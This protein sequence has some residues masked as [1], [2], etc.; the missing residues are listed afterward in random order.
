MDETYRDMKTLSGPLMRVLEEAYGFVIRNTPTLAHFKKGKLARR[1]E[2][3]YPAHAIREGLVN[4]F[5]HRDYAD[6]KGGIAVH[7]YPRRLEIW[8]SGSL[9]EGVTLD[10]LA[11]GHISVLRNPDIAQVLHLRGWM[12]KVGRGSLMILNECRNR[13]LPEPT[14]ESSELGVTLTFHAGKV[15]GTQ[16][17]TT[18]VSSLSQ[19][20]PK[21]VPSEVVEQMLR[22]AASV[23]DLKSLMQTAGQRNRTR[24]RNT[25]LKP[26]LDAGVIE[27]T[28]P[29]KPR[30]SK[31][32]YRLTPKGEKILCDA[33]HDRTVEG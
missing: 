16:L 31:Q 22:A 12:E 23:I 28:V 2:P 10:R 4:A 9:P 13:G 14:W 6:Y 15:V 27:L 33:V 3:L 30:S 11:K 18:D 8:N 21:S 32:R 19:V 24:F 29:D 20:C 17:E 1:D 26:L 7:V 5:A 25:I